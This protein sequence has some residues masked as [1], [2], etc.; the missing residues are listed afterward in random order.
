[1]S[2][3]DLGQQFAS[4]VDQHGYLRLTAKQVAFMR[5]LAL[6]EM[7]RNGDDADVRAYRHHGAPTI[8]GYLPDGRQWTIAIYQNGAG[9]FHFS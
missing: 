3:V 1:M 4:R 7:R 2:A 6:Q 9:V 8:V 5:S